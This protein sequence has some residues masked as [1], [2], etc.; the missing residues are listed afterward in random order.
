MMKTNYTKHQV[1]SVMISLTLILLPF[2]LSV[3]GKKSDFAGSWTYNKE[4]S[5]AWQ[6][7]GERPEGQ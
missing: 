7:Q 5:E 4:L 3:Q 6:P 1:F 2:S